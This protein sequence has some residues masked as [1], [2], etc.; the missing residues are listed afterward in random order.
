MYYGAYCPANVRKHL[1]QSNQFLQ[2]Y[3]ILA[4]DI[5]KG[6]LYGRVKSKLKFKGKQIP[7]NDIWIAAVAIQFN[8]PLFTSD[9]HFKEVENIVMVEVT[10][11]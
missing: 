7:E 8:L 5:I 3:T 11:L 2:N 1:D 10:V 4:P 9:K 6:D